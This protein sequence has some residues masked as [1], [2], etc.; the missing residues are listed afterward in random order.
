MD[1]RAKTRGAAIS[2]PLAKSPCVSLE[3]PKPVTVAG[4]WRQSHAPPPA[5]LVLPLKK[6]MLP[7]LVMSG[8][9]FLWLIFFSPHGTPKRWC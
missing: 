2:E 3:R 8:R 7:E 9:H 5:T 4:G 6:E 1:L